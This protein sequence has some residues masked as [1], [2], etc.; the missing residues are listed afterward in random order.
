MAGP[1][2]LA[3][4]LAGGKGER[5]YPLTRERGKPAVPFGAKYRIVDFV[6]SNFINSGIYALYVLVQYKAQSLIEHLR[7]AWRLGGL[8][9][10]FVIVVPP[11]M[12]WGETWYQGTADAVY[13]NINLLRDFH[14][15][16]VAIFGADHVY[17]MDIAQMLD[18]HRDHRADITV[19]ALPVPIEEAQNFGILASDEEGRI[20]RFDEKP[21]VAAPMPSDSTRAYASMGNYLF[22][23]DVLIEALVEDAR[24]ST[25]HD[26]GRTIIPELVP[27]G[28]VY[29]YNFMDNAIPG[30]HPHEEVGYWRDV[31]TIAAYWHAHM[32]LLGPEPRLDLD[33]DR[34]P[35]LTAPFRGPSTR[36]IEGDVMDSILGEGA[37]ID[38]AAVRRSIIGRGVRVGRGASV[39][40]SII[41]ERTTIG[42]GARVRRAVVDRYN[43]I[44]EGA[45]IGEDGET[46]RRRFHVDPSGLVVVPRGQTR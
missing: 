15:D 29:A 13:Q 4:I 38:G 28:G 3:I 24:R 42:P 14:P 44:P 45:H 25:D 18:F 22:N 33:N 43:A 26:F 34:W 5:L 7:N 19:A 10:H 37:L 9:D 8:P 39:E 11:Q 32:D 35:I 46:D 27:R 31:G 23:H 2:V 36:I 16:I 21:K 40:D 1:R 17:R 30:I 6:I 20:T 41:M 12:R